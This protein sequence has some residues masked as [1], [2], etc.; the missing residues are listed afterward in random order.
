MPAPREIFDGFESILDVFASNIRN[1]ERVAYILCD[2]LIELTCKTKAHQHDNQF[3]RRCGFHRAWNAPG[4]NLA[5][6]GLGGRVQNRRDTRNTM[7]H[8]NAAV[9]V[10]T[11]NCADAILDVKRT[12]NQIWRDTTSRNLSPPY[13]VLLR[14]VELYSSNGNAMKRQQFEDQM[15]KAQWRGMTDNRRAKINE[16]I[17]EPGLRLH[18]SLSINQSYELVEQILDSL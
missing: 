6:G 8:G 11:E 16:V 15:R 9:T 1:R 4:V 14:I 12:I 17:V 13:I 3:D 10:T 5:P 18:W 2:N 7:Q